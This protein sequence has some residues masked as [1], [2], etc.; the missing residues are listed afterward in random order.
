MPSSV[1]PPG[2]WLLPFYSFCCSEQWM[3]THTFP[4]MTVGGS[5]QP[6]LCWWS[7]DICS[8]LTQFKVM[9]ITQLGISTISQAEAWGDPTKPRFG[10][11]YL[12][13]APAQEGG[14]EIWDSCC[15]GPS[16]S[17]PSPLTGWD[18]KK[19]C[20]TYQYQ[21]GLALCIHAVMQG[22]S[23]H[24]PLQCWAPQHYGRWCTK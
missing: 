10:M 15:M 18:G 24:P 11:A 16:L 1:S 4:K 7:H 9:E 21:A 22:L 2:I 19:V 23:A 8:L 17:S 13:L 14:K 5:K 6:R 20:L 12:L 3:T